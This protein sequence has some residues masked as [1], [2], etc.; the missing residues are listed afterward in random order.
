M[1]RSS[2]G[3]QDAKPEE[4]SCCSI[5]GRLVTGKPRN[6]YGGECIRFNH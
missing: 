5:I 4:W 3:D 1:R 6:V 2:S